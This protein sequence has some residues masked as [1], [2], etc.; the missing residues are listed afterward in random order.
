MLKP[1]ARQDDM[2]DVVH[3]YSEHDFR[4]AMVSARGF[5]WSEVQDEGHP[6]Q[7]RPP[8]LCRQCEPQH[9]AAPARVPRGQQF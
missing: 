4:E 7:V 1:R 9:D 8:D 6:A 3:L 2:P 5:E